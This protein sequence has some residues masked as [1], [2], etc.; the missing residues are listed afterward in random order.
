MR[1]RWRH[2]KLQCLGLFGCLSVGRDM[3][4]NGLGGREAGRGSR[5]SRAA[6]ERGGLRFR[7]EMGG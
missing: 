2:G 3:R 4:A 1:G 5:V 7:P 6:V